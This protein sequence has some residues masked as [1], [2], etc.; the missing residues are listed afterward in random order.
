CSAT[1][2]SPPRLQDV[3]KARAVPGLILPVKDCAA[4]GS[5]TFL[6]QCLL[7]SETGMLGT[8]ILRAAERSADVECIGAS[9]SL[10]RFL[11]IAFGAFRKRAALRG[12]L[13]KP[14]IVCHNYNLSY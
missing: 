4:L 10:R 5:I 7:R 12:F 3:V 6:A 9:V 2:A 8:I 11:G 13:L 14:F 1:H